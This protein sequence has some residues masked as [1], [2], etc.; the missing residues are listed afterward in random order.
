M[1]KKKNYLILQQIIYLAHD[2]VR[3]YF[4]GEEAKVV[5]DVAGRALSDFDG[6]LTGGDVDIDAHNYQVLYYIYYIF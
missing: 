5:V 2:A 4:S 1:K 3:K 6:Q